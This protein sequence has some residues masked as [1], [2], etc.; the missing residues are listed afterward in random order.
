MFPSLLLST[1]CRRDFTEFTCQS[2]SVG[3]NDVLWG[4]CW[5]SLSFCTFCSFLSL[6]SC[7]GHMC[8]CLRHT[9]VFIAKFFFW[10]LT[11]KFLDLRSMLNAFDKTFA[12]HLFFSSLI[13]SFIGDLLPLMADYHQQMVTC[14][15]TL[16]SYLQKLQESMMKIQTH[17]MVGNLLSDSKWLKDLH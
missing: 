14:I 15:T 17:Q 4:F 10:H 1:H 5:C 8:S 2:N 3:R 11:C 6:V 9:G 16:Y 7:R 12:K 13:Q